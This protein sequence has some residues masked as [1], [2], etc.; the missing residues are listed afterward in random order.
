MQLERAADSILMILCSDCT[1]LD[2]RE[3]IPG[4][5]A[6]PGIHVIVKDII[7][8]RFIQLSDTQ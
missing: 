3:L 6:I 2:T 4:F 5:A 7:A 8:Q 1:G